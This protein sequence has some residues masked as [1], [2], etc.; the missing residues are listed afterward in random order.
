MTSHDGEVYY[1]KE[2]NRFFQVRGIHDDYLICGGF[3]EFY[4]D[5]KTMLREQNL[6]Y[7]LTGA[8]TLVRA[9]DECED[10]E[11][12]DIGGLLIW[13]VK[14]SAIMTADAGS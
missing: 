9:I 14:A 8:A 10:A 11:T 2:Y 5:A 3:S 13:K 4:D 7:R 1:S 12:V 6:S